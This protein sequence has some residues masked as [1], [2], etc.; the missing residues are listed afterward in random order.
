MFVEKN[1]TIS[2][3]ALLKLQAVTQG[4]VMTPDDP[5]YDQ[6]RMNWNVNVDQYPAVIVAARNTNDV[7]QAVRFAIAHKLQIAVKSTGHGALVPINDGLLLVTSQMTAVEIDADNQTARAEAGAKWG[8]VLQ[9]AQQFGLAP[10]LGS[11]PEVGVIGYTL[12]G[13]MGWLARKYGMAVDS[14]ISFE[15]VTPAGELVQASATENSD[16]YWALRG[17]GGNFGVVVA[18]TMRLYPVATV[19]AGNLYYPISLAREVYQR[20]REWV[21]TAPYE[22][23]SSVVMMNYP[24]LPQLPDVLRGQTYIQVRGCYTGP[25][26]DGES[27]LSFW[28]DWQ[29]PVLDDFKARPFSEA[30]LIS[31]D[32]VDPMP[33]AV[34]GGWLREIDD[35]V[36]DA[37]IE[38][39]PPTDGPPLLVFAEIR[40]A[41]GAIKGLNRTETAFSLRDA[42]F[43]LEMISVTPTPEAHTAVLQYTN[44]IKQRIASALTGGIYMNF[45]DGA[46]ARADAPKGYTAEAYT[47]LQQVKAAYDPDNRFDHSFNLNA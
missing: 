40:H 31:N 32:P 3:D 10:L 21:K 24:P 38:S 28:R 9:P 13:G 35:T 1:A 27:L 44:G 47:R 4:E 8:M 26:E 29:T 5:G 22:L 25:V 43:L 30:A 23:T 6:A 18:M 45:T 7:V 37:L 11:S 41:G 16:L 12:G 17:G 2:H 46:E 15:I 36:I 19:Y 42:D 34:S 20:Y 33:A 39:V 14:V